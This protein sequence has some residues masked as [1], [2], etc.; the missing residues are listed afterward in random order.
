M[1]LGLACSTWLG[2]GMPVVG[3]VVGRRVEAGESYHHRCHASSDGRGH[4]QG[5]G[6]EQDHGPWDL[7]G[8]LSAV[9]G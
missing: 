2:R 6:Q 4:D 7:G 3:V 1:Y 5:G 9:G 8:P